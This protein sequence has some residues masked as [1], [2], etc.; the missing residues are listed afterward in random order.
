MDND[1]SEEVLGIGS[2]QL[3]LHI[4]ASYF[5]TMCFMHLDFDIIYFKL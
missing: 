2:Y 3:T 4:G 5:Y 1:S